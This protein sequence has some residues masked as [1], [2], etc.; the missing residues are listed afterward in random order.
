MLF[1][2][3]ESRSAR[4]F[5]HYYLLL[6]TV[7]NTTLRRDRSQGGQPRGGQPPRRRSTPDRHPR[8]EWRFPVRWRAVGRFVRVRQVQRRRVVQVANRGPWGG[9]TEGATALDAGGKSGQKDR[10]GRSKSLK[11]GDRWKRWNCYHQICNQRVGGSNPSASSMK[12]SCSVLD[13][14]RL[15]A[16]ASDS[17][18]RGLPH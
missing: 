13:R 17:A 15:G 11:T 10:P 8:K 18:K 7:L 4:C 16:R 1:G 14:A 2:S 9:A 6:L 5:G 3:R 12:K